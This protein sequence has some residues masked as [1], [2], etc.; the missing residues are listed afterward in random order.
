MVKISWEARA[1]QL[2]HSGEARS[3]E[4]PL[5][6]LVIGSDSGSTSV[7]YATGLGLSVVNSF[8]FSWGVSFSGPHRGDHFLLLGID[9][10]DLSDVF[11]PSR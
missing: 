2:F 7:W 9:I 5:S 10:K 3:C 6:V 4:E 11:S 1:E 8:H